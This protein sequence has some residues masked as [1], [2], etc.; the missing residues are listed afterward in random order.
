MSATNFNTSNY[1]YRKLMGNGLTYRIPRFQRDYSWTEEEW[2]D[3]WLDIIDTFSP[4]GESNH[5]LGYVVLQSQDDRTFDVIDGQQRLTTLSLIILAALKNIQRAISAGKD[6]ERNQ[7]RLE[8]LRQTYIGYLDPVT[9]VPRSK[10][11]L[12][13]H[14]D[15]YYQTYLVA[16]VERLPQRGFKASEHLLR[17]A[18]TWFDSKLEKYI[19]SLFEVDRG[20]AIAQFVD[21]LSDN[22]FFTVITVTD[23]LNAYRVF[24]TLNARGVKLSSTDLLKNYLFSVIHKSSQHEQELLALEER[25]ESMVGRLGGESFPD[26]LRVHWNSRYSFARQNEL[27][28]KI[29][30]KIKDRAAAFELLRLM[31]EDIDTYLGL[32]QPELASWSKNAKDSVEKLKM[33]GVKQPFT[34]LLAAYRQFSISD[35]EKIL[36][37]CVVISFRYHTIGSLPPQ[38]Q[39]RV[40]TRVANQVSDR[41]FTQASET[42]LALKEVYP[43]DKG[44]QAA[45]ASKSIQTKQT[46]NN[47]IVRYILCQLEIHSV[48][49]EYDFES[50]RFNIEHILPQNPDSGW[51]NF[52]DEE[53]DAFKYRLGNMTLC[54]TNLNRQL[55]NDDYNSKREGYNNSVFSLTRKLAEKNQDWNVKSISARQNWMAKQAV[56]IWR[57]DELHK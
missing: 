56:S 26:F 25:W 9:L 28:K 21:R 53:V 6:P 32:N 4:T 5:Y 27:F 10:L 36:K 20:M 15:S 38:E 45:F 43:D 55:G 49:Q 41:R 47:R 13:R 51:D 35:F 39:E 2:E 34:L 3:L 54:E 44:F 50:N 40:Y 31:D 22:L 48:G 11:S 16:L 37:A 33:L 30:G 24:E 29:R 46:R 18:F 19:D 57:I 8:Q 7:L 12:N 14:N 52:S 23:E 17:K 42:I 1:T